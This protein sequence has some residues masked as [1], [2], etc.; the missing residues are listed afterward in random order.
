MVSSDWYTAYSHEVCTAGT[1]IPFVP[2][3]SANPVD[4]MR[5]KI[6]GNIAVF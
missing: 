4:A 1:S 2:E 6:D 5:H 3:S